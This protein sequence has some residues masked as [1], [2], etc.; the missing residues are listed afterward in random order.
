MILAVL[1]FAALIVIALAIKPIRKA[2]GLTLVI[3]GA[4]FSL[5]GIG[6]IIGAPMILVGGVVVFV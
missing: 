1:L 5:T 2:S 3:L 6:I 4:I